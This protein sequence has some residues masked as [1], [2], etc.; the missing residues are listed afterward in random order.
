MGLGPPRMEGLSKTRGWGSREE[1]EQPEG[2]GPSDWVGG[3]VG[4]SPTVLRA[5]PAWASKWGGE[6]SGLWGAGQ[7][8]S[9]V[10]GDL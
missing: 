6:Q 2:K 8:P 10:A 4:E 7:A 5:R 1:P 3:S 9:Q